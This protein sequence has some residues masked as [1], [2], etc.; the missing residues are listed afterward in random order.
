[1]E[2]SVIGTVPNLACR[3]CGEAKPGQILLSQKI[4]DS[5]HG[6]IEVGPIRDLTLKGFHRPVPAFELVS[7]RESC[8]EPTR[9][10][11]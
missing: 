2:Y 10:S 6:K 3:L 4:F 11:W 5:V 9:G 7:W 8:D 1:M